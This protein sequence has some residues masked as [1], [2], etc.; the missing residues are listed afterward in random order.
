MLREIIVS[1]TRSKGFSKKNTKTG[2][3]YK[4][5]VIGVS[6]GGINAL[7]TILPALPSDYSIPVIIAQ[8]IGATSDGHWIKILDNISPLKVKEA[9]EKEKIKKGHVYIA[10]PNYHL[11][12]E[13]DETLSLSIDEKV[14]YA[15][16]SIDVL[17]ES[18]AMSYNENLVGII[19][20]GAN[21]DGAMGLKKIKERKGLTI[22]EDP[23]T[24]EAPAMPAH[25]IAGIQPDHILSLK[26]IAELLTQLS[27]K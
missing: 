12:V 25:A 24:A 8:H 14:N 13:S 23:K 19:L 15:R 10:P 5:I 27:K 1:W 9:D 6:T 11:M 21:N 18:A 3:K 4:A 26:K 22:V 7:K 20:T 17:F 16:P 2:V